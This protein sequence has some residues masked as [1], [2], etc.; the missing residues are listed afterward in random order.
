MDLTKLDMANA[1]S[2]GQDLHLRN[3]ATGERLF[4]DDEEPMVITLLGQDSSEY[5]QGV[6]RIANEQ[7]KNRKKAPS[8]EALEQEAVSLLA[9]VTAGWSGIVE[10]GEVVEFSRDAA[11]RLYSR[12]A[13]I[14][15]QVDEFTADRSNFLLTA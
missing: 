4:N 1:A 12:Y 10:N 5:R 7:V 8:A 14:R 2:R 15:E 3:P 11:E 13:W 6:R 9:S